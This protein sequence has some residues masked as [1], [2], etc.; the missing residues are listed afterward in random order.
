MQRRINTVEALSAQ[1]AE[2][3]IA[4]HQ[5]EQDVEQ[6]KLEQSSKQDEAKKLRD[7]LSEVNTE[8]T[9]ELEALQ[10]KSSA[11]GS[12]VDSII[13]NMQNLLSTPC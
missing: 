11:M 10:Q 6:L 2:A 7:T 4:L 13:E 3:N 12:E 8:A 5:I 9:R 1:L